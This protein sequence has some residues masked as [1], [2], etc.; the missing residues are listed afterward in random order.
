M[1]QTSVKYGIDWI[2]NL[3]ADR[4]SLTKRHDGQSRRT[5]DR[6]GWTTIFRSLSEG[7]HVSSLQHCSDDEGSVKRKSAANASFGR[8]DDAKATVRRL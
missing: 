3:K 1:H 7:S 5:G 6:N 4:N 8:L 2:A